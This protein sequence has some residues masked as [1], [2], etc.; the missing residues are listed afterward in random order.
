[1]NKLPTLYSH[2]FTLDPLMHW[3]YIHSEPQVTEINKV[4]FRRILINKTSKINFNNCDIVV[5]TL[6][7]DN[8][9]YIPLILSNNRIKEIEKGISPLIFELELMSV[10]INNPS[11]KYTFHCYN[12]QYTPYKP[13]THMKQFYNIKPKLR[14]KKEILNDF[15]KRIDILNGSEPQDECK[16]NWMNL[17]GKSVNMKCTY[18]CDFKHICGQKN[19]KTNL[20]K[21]KRSKAVSGLF[22]GL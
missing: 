5:P 9:F 8:E 21:A 13:N 12:K 4:G 3:H 1:M 17:K 19:K 6:I 22:E 7:Y 2:H 11:L 10:I 20:Y 18:Y 14:N 15:E 16:P